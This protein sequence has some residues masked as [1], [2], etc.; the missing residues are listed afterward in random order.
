MTF[1]GIA[2][3]LLLLLVVGLWVL[4]SG[5]RWWLCA[6]QECDNYDVFNAYSDHHADSDGDDAYGGG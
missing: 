3:M 4:T 5:W 2:L 6:N 1:Y